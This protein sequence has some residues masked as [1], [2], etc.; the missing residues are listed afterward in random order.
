VRR[1]LDGAYVKDIDRMAL[2]SNLDV[3][4]KLVANLFPGPSLLLQ[5][6]FLAGSNLPHLGAKPH[7]LTFSH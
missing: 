1:M 5:L 7:T 6:N 2:K 3:E 4:G